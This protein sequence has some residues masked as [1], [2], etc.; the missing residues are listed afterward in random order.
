MDK[1][2]R[3]KQISNLYFENRM[4]FTE[5]SKEI[6]I[7]IRQVSKIVKQDENYIEEKEKRKKQNAI[8]HSE[9]TKEIMRKKEIH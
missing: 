3:N 6:N 9:N 1:S 4:T 7:S 2:I 8:K 5:I